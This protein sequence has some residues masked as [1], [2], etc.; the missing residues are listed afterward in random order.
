MEKG[1]I[2]S[3]QNMIT[4]PRH[5][6]REESGCRKYDLVYVLFYIHMYVDLKFIK[7]K[8]VGENIPELGV[9]RNFSFY[10]FL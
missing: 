6:I 10:T 8:A 5:I 9:G 2:N 4:S 3:I 1:S 7:P